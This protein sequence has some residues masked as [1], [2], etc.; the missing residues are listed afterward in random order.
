MLI[1]VC[2]MKYKEN[3]E[4][5]AALGPDMLGF[6]FYEPSP[7][8]VDHEQLEDIA[9]DV[10]DSIRKV[11]VF[12]NEQAETVILRCKKFG[13]EYAQLHGEESPEYCRQ[14]QDQGLKVIKVFHVNDE[15]DLGLVGPYEGNTD[16]YLFDTKTPAY[17]GSGK[18]FDWSLLQEYSYST[19]YLLSG[20]I[21]DGDALSIREMRLPGMEGIDANSGLE[22]SPGV[23]DVFKVKSLINQLRT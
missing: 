23:K 7:R 6:I 18:K 15:F 11:G 1:K 4:Q 12:V 10:P 2:G 9:N 17:G 8:D 5:V 13:F 3:V 20:G 21:T 14:I 22:V 19:P 16:M